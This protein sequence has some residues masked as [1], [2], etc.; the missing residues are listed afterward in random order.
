VK[1]GIVNAGETTSEI[2]VDETFMP[3]ESLMEAVTV[4]VPVEVG[5]Q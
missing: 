5:V 2:G 4:N 3:S 1:V